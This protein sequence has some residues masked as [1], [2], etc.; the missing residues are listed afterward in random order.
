[1]TRR[2][3]DQVERARADLAA[4]LEEDGPL[5]E[6]QL[7]AR[8]LGYGSVAALHKV[9]PTTAIGQTLRDIAYLKGRGRLVQAWH[10]DP[11]SWR[12]HLATSDDA[13]D[14]EDRRDVERMSAGWQEADR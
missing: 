5:T 11:R 9:W 7:I 6:W 8:V 3:K 12:W 13:V 1:M 2:S 4:A 14:E 10:Q